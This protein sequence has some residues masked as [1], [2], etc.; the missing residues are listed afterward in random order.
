MIFMEKTMFSEIYYCNSTIQHF[1]IL[2][3][4]LKPFFIKKKTLQID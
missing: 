2:T 3:Q 1:K 4:D